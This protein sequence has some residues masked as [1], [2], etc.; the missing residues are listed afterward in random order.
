MK[1]IFTIIFLVFFLN[2]CFWNSGN[3]WLIN[4]SEENFSIKI[5]NNWEII[6]EKE[7]VLPKPK[8]WEIEFAIKSKNEKDWFF[9]NLTILS[10]KQKSEVSASDYIDVNIKNPENNYFEYEEIEAKKFKFENGDSSKIVIFDA[11]YNDKTPKLKFLQTAN[12]CKDEKMY[13][14][15]LAIS[16]DI[17]DTSRYENILSSFSCKK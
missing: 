1:K 12:F 13:F 16:K 5:P 11:R 17:K 4:H 7:K 9:N 14:L 15:T 8:S 3:D 6:T 2:S 10:E